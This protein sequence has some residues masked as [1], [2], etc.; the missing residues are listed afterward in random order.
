MQFQC[1][2]GRIILPL[3]NHEWNKSAISRQFAL[4]SS[5]TDFIAKWNDVM[6]SSAQSHA[7]IQ[8]Q[9][10]HSGMPSASIG[11]LQ[12]KQI[13]KIIETFCS[14]DESQTTNITLSFDQHFL[15]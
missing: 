11:T 10:P 5:S 1:E 6:Q 3:R 14:A 12:I 9:L 4:I 13:H 7:E 2:N 8:V 15:H